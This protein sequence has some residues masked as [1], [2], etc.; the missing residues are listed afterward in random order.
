MK[1]CSRAKVNPNSTS[2]QSINIEAKLKIQGGQYVGIFMPAH[3]NINRIPVAFHDAGAFQHSYCYMKSVPELYGSGKFNVIEG[4]VGMQ[5]W[6]EYADVVDLEMV[7]S[8]STAN[9]TDLVERGANINAT[10]AAVLG[11]FKIYNS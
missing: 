2:V 6:V 1:A 7:A 11:T 3:L 10:Y 4:H 8:A 9:L 5:T